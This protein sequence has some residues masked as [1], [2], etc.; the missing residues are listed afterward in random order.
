MFY[1]QIGDDNV[2][3]CLQRCNAFK[4]IICAVLFI[5][6][7]LIMYAISPLGFSTSTILICVL[8]IIGCY[9]CIKGPQ[10]PSFI[11]NYCHRLCLPRKQKRETKKL[12]KA[13]NKF[14]DDLTEILLNELFEHWIVMEILNYM[15]DLEYIEIDGLILNDRDVVISC[16]NLNESL[17]KNL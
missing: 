4:C 16:N 14:Y 15:K 11:S 5:T 3:L 17:L 2:T 7:L 10:C 8:S 1:E 13:I 6:A 12:Q 9:C